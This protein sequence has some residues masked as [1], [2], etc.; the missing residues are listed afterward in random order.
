VEPDEPAPDPDVAARRAAIAVA[1]HAR[2]LEA[3][4][5]GLA[6]ADGRVR[7]AAVRALIAM[8]AATDQDVA[9]AIEDPSPIVRRTVCEA[10]AEAGKDAVTGAFASLLSD[11]EPAVVEAAAFAVGE[12]DDRDAVEA[13]ATIATTHADALCRESAV[14]A[15]G[16]IGDPRGKA[17]VIAALADT[18]YVRRRAV[19][20]LAAFSGTDVAEALQGRLADRDWQVR[21]AAEDIIGVN[22][23]IAP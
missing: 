11:P 17:A 13:L 22:R 21:Q 8:R 20:A 6:D 1:G 14:A 23:Q 12:L 15:L 18:N 19:V 7:A 2:D 10:A 5:V 3:V 9:R 4:R 16:A